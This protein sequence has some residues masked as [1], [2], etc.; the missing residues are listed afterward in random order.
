MQSD[1]YG[2]YVGIEVDEY[3]F[4]FVSYIGSFCYNEYV[5][6]KFEMNFCCI[7]VGIFIFYY[8]NVGCWFS[9]VIVF[10]FYQ[11]I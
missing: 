10:Y 4:F 11:K 9:D 5:C 6:V 2:C 8:I 3:Y 7:L 1:D